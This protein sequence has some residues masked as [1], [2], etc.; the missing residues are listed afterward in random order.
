MSTIEPIY[1]SLTQSS[2][3]SPTFFFLGEL[4]HESRR[5]KEGYKAA[6]AAE[7]VA[8]VI[9]SGHIETVKGCCDFWHA[10]S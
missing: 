3:W 8:L 7:E 2:E 1:E 5:K 6:W 4:K 9:T 10:K